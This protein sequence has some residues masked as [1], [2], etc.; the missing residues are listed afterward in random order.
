MKKSQRMILIL[1]LATLSINI[2][3]ISELIDFK[4]IIGSDPKVK[5]LGRSIQTRFREGVINYVPDN[6]KPPPLNTNEMLSSTQSSISLNSKWAD[7]RF[8]FRKTIIIHSSQV[9]ENLTSFPVL[10]DL[11]DS[12]LKNVAQANG[13]DIIFMDCFGNKLDH[14]IEHFDRDYNSTHSHL[15][16]WVKLNLSSTYETVFSMYYGNPYVDTQETSENVWDENFIGV[17]HFSEKSGIR[18]DSTRNHHDGGPQNFDNDEATIGQI[19]GA[20]QF[21][22]VNDYIDTYKYPFELGLDGKNPKT[23]S[24]WVN[25]KDFNEGG[26]FE[27]GQYASMKYLAIRASSS[28]NVWSIDW[29]GFSHDFNII[30]LNQWVYFVITYEEP[31]INIYGKSTGTKILETQISKSINLNIG[32]KVTLKFG[33]A[34]DNFFNGTIDEVRVSNVARSVA[35]IKAEFSN[36]RDPSS[37]YS[38]GVQEMDKIPPQIN[39][40]GVEDKGEGT[41][42]F[43]AN[44]TDDLSPI[45]NVLIEINGSVYDM[46]QDISGLWIYQCPWVNFGEYCEYQVVNASDAHDNWLVSKSKMMSY[47]F[48]KDTLPPDVLQWEYILDT[49]S[50]EANVTDYWG[51]IDTVI[52]NVTT[53]NIAATMV[54]IAIASNKVFIYKNDTL[55]IPNG[56]MKFL[57]FVNDTSGNKYYSPLHS[58]YVLINHAP[59]VKNITLNPLKLYSSSIIELSYDYYDEDSHAEAGTEIRW[60]KNNGTGF[61][62]QNDYNDERMI[63]SF[64]LVKNDKWYVTVRPKDGDLFGET[65][66]SSELIGP[67]VVL[68]SPPEIIILEDEHPEFIIED[69]DLI[70]EKSYYRF[71]DNDGDSDQS[72]ILW[73]KNGVLESEFTNQTKIDAN[74]TQP[75]ERWYYVIRPYDGLDQGMDQKSPIIVIE[76]RP[77]INSYTIIPIN[78][79]EGHYS[80]EI[81]TTD[82]RN[83]IKYVQ[84]LIIYNKSNPPITDIVASPKDGTED[85]WM[86]EFHLT[87]YTYLD[88]KIMVKIEVFTE[89]L[90]YSEKETITQSLTFNFIAKDTAPPRVKNAFFVVD[91]KLQPSSINFYAE[92]EE[93]G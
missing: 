64:A 63:P 22:A 93:Y 21:D 41:P 79:I 13:N 17:W 80:L 73:Y 36:Q 51:E 82:P 78:D 23:I 50:F 15:V 8:E 3:I 90:D 30:S 14:E 88:K 27:F 33:M 7:V 56:P 62:L 4:D 39:D 72:I 18:Y 83:E 45:K 38:I 47:I 9:K 10:L 57:I 53:Y 65:L 52:V 77:R 91:D 85:I 1:L 86:F 29:G 31:I 24:M 34:S 32:D 19:N 84:Y 66:N 71:T 12:D 16:S 11:Y 81:N 49:H 59:I 87:D 5:A 6:I 40:L 26:I 58:G 89:L 48:N 60:Y 28:P 46:K 54:P 25:T 68:N 76:S 92:V 75:A 55:E 69:Q 44:V 20:D 74:V 43:Y 61:L 70:L 42:I 67:V 2:I 35:W 37:F